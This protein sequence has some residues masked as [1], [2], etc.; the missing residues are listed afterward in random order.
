M[1][2]RVWLWT[3]LRTCICKRRRMVFLVRCKELLVT[4]KI[5]RAYCRKDLAGL[6]ASYYLKDTHT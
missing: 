5:R 3:L 1:G 4:W 2:G 6:L